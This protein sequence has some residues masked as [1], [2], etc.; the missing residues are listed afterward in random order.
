MM[1]QTGHAW[2]QRMCASAKQTSS[3]AAAHFDLPQNKCLPDLG[4]AQQQS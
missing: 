4:A 1:I 2:K 3:V